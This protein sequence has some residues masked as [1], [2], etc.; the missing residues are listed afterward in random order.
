ME[1]VSAYIPSY[2]S[3]ETLARSIESVQAQSP[4]ID[5]II[6]IDD[7]SVDDSS[8]LA[9]SLGVRVI[10]HDSNLGRGAV[11]ARAMLET[12]HEI[13]LCLDSTNVLERTF[14]R[15]AL[16]HLDEDEKIAAVYGRIVQTSTLSATERWRA[17]H[18]FKC[19]QKLTFSRQAPLIT[20]GAVLRKSIVLKLG[21]F[22]ATL[23]HNEDSDLGER[24]IEAGYD[25]VFDPELNVISIGKNNL[26]QLIE[27]YWRWYAG[28]EEDVSWQ[29][30][31]RQVAYSLKCMAIEDIAAGDPDSLLISL[32]CPH[33][34]FW[35]SWLGKKNRRRH[36]TEYG[37]NYRG[38]SLGWSVE[39]E[40]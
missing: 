23:R 15:D 21:N 3:S 24:L 40:V 5:E 27:R 31:A 16:L 2:N 37:G 9:R 12:S 6:V 38:S 25:V 33:Y 7:G 19:D 13:V 36:C 8:Q 14:L 30:Y 35:R 17:R 34:Q 39:G 10:K 20:Y 18:L 1:S 26:W 4:K 28:K 29:G 11:R 32:I 22:D